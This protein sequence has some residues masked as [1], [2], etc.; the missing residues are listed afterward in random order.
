MDHPS[1]GA[2]PFC[3]VSRAPIEP[4]H[5]KAVSASSESTILRNLKYDLWRNRQEK[6]LCPVFGE[7]P[8]VAEHGV[9]PG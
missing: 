2:L 1:L 6:L 3:Q 4:S 5:A 7:R 9:Q 8:L